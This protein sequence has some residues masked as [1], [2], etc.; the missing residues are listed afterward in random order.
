LAKNEEGEFELILGNRQL[1]SVF[2][3]AVILFGVF[4][5]MGY[6]IGRNSVP[7]APE[8]ARD[9]PP[10]ELHWPRE[11]SAKPPETAPQ[12]P[13]VATPVPVG[14]AKASP[15]ETKP[16]EPA[17]IAPAA[18]APAAT[19][20]AAPPPAPAPAAPPREKPSAAGPPV[21]PRASAPA[22]ASVS[23]A[24][25]P[26]DYW[27]VVATARPEAEI[28]A[29]ALSKKGFHAI[30]APASRDGIFR[31]L[32]GPMKDA[33]TQAQTRTALEAAGFKNP[34]RQRY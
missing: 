23:G 24:P 8:T 26:G 1:I 3:I 12:E 22:R 25:A 4:F 7:A 13:T 14:D 16:A 27:Q 19:T 31:V 15:S 6:I 21:S 32:V 17:A 29:E 11:D 10:K 33:S 9:V 18:S 34:I 30:V 5:A 2:M 28:V 20:P